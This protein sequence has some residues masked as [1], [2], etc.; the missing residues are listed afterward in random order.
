M[1]AVTSAQWKTDCAVKRSGVIKI[2]HRDL[3][4]NVSRCHP[5]AAHGRRL[6]R[7][8]SQSPPVRSDRQGDKTNYADGYMWMQGTWRACRYMGTGRKVGVWQRVARLQPDGWKSDLQ[9]NRRH[10]N[11][12]VSGRLDYHRRPRVTPTA[13]QRQ[14]GRQKERDRQPLWHLGRS[15]G[16]LADGRVTCAA[17]G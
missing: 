4:G 2:S 16:K 17:L 13:S 5:R 7:E 11:R 9:V 10:R 15:W 3:N 1:A 6:C 12:Q 14:P 8:L